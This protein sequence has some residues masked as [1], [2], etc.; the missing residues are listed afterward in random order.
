MF[1]YFARER[2]KASALKPYPSHLRK[3][4]EIE[5]PPLTVF[6]HITD[7]FLNIFLGGIQT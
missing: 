2:N 6:V 5:D 7:H 4:E 3:Q 1:V